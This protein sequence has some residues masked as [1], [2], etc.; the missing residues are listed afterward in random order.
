MSTSTY[1]YDD[2]ESRT[3]TIDTDGGKFHGVIVYDDLD[4]EISEDWGGSDPNAEFSERLYEYSGDRMLS[5]TFKQG[6]PLAVVETDTLRY[7]CR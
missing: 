6:K 2:A 3:I 1:T 5:A 7:D 4:N